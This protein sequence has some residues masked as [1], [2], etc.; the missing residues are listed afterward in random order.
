MFTTLPTPASDFLYGAGGTDATCITQGFFIQLGTIAS[1][2][3]VSLAF[4]Y[5]M[6]I[7]YDWSDDRLKSKRVFLFAIPIF[8]GMAF[9]FAGKMFDMLTTCTYH[10]IAKYSLFVHKRN[11]LLRQYDAVVQ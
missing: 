4:F 5:L 7:K 1:Y 11:P 10:K 6:K 3:N 2:I 9:A 8:I